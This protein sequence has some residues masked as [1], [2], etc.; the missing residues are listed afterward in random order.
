MMKNTI[1]TFAAIFLSTLFLRGQAPGLVSY[2]TIIRNTDNELISNKVVGIRISILKDNPNGIPV[3]Q[4]R[5]YVQTNLN[6]LAYLVI[7]GGTPIKGKFSDIDWSTGPYYIQSE[8]DI[9][10]GQDYKIAVFTQIL[11]VPYAIHAKSAETLLG[12]INEVDPQFNASV[13]KGITAID[14]A[15][16][17]RKASGSGTGNAIDSIYNNSVAKGISAVDTASWN[18][19]LSSFT[20]VD[21]Q[22]NASL[23]KSISAAD[24]TSWNK[25]LS[26]FTEVDPQF[27]ASVAKGISAVDTASWNKKLSSFTEVDP[28]FNAS[29]AKGI[30]AVD[31]ASWNK[32]LSSFTEVDPQ[33]NASVAKSISAADTAAWNKKLSSFTEVDPQFNASVAKSISAADTTYWNKKLSSFTEVDPQFNASVAK[34]ISAADTTY[35]NKKLSSF[36]EVDPQF[37][38]S[39]AKSISAID[40]TY[41]NKKLSSFTEVDPRLPIGNAKGNI[42]YWDGAAWQILEPGLAG[43]KISLSKQGMPSWIGPTFPVLT[44]NTASVIGVRNVNLGG[45]I[46]SDGN[47]PVIERGVVLHTSTNPTTSNNKVPIGDGIGSFTSTIEN[48]KGNTIYFVR[49]YAITALGTEYGNEINFTTLPAS[50]PIA[51][52]KPITSITNRTAAS[53]GIILNDGGSDIIAKGICWSNNPNP[54]ILNANFTTE[55]VGIDSFVSFITGLSP[56]ASYYVRAYVTSGSGTSY[57]NELFFQT[58][59]NAPSLNPTFSAFNISEI[60]SHTASFSATISSDINHIASRGFCWSP[61][62]NPTI[63]NNHVEVG[64]GVGSFSIKQEGFTGGGI[65]YHARAFAVNSYGVFYGEEKIFFTQ[66][67]VPT[68]QLSSLKDFGLSAFAYINIP[69]SGGKTITQRGIVY[70]TTENPTTLNDKILS[71]TGIGEFSITITG[72]TQKTTYFVRAFASNEVGTAYSNQIKL[73]T[74][75]A[76]TTIS[77]IEGNTYNTINIGNQI[78]M[79]SNLSTSRF[80]NG[81][82]IPYILNSTQWATTKSP[83]LSFYNHDNNFESNYGK[84]YNWYAVADPQGLCPVGWHIPTNSDWTVLSDNLGGLN[85][86]GGRMKNAGTTFWIFPSNGTNASGFN[87][88][89]GG[90]RNV[91]G[92]FG[93]L[94]HNAYWWSATD[95]NEQKAFSRSIVYTD[96]V[97]SVNSSLKNQGFSIRCLKD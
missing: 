80:R 12:K 27:N 92:T 77:D 62:P 29:V 89:P 88:L 19:K 58:N 15:N 47:S 65:K 9:N 81:V 73:T 95:E 18:K 23:A 87:G 97:L 42:L 37:N 3:Y 55:G 59:T 17:N 13:A 46:L 61:L 54:T 71:G 24:T 35:W 96:N 1:F 40:T 74:N 8:T 10:G 39:V 79:T 93:I 69:D 94:L 51:S 38:A 6:G 57:G 26:S 49:A 75:T 70:S 36:T 53:G 7:G 16:W 32:K 45:N 85:L 91:D 78:W 11:S 82:Y 4:E 52:T 33:F 66:F 84:Q 72:L 76:S 14:T 22:F 83:A 48:L 86:A 41:W 43:Q 5:H 56:N 21:P 50:L 28:Q 68:I 60:G 67:D 64:K 63:L 25:K 20:E 30:S 2:Q 34:S 31:T 90:F 44:T